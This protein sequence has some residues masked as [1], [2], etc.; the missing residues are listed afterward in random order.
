MI[1]LVLKMSLQ[2]HVDT[3]CQCLIVSFAISVVD[4]VVNLQSGFVAVE[5]YL[6]DVSG[7]GCLVLG[8]ELKESYFMWF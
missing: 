4:V 8:I 3:C 2:K 1:G 7:K 5:G 6:F